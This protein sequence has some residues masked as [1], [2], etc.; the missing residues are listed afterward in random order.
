MRGLIKKAIFLRFTYAHTPNGG[1][2]VVERTWKLVELVEVEWNGSLMNVEGD[3]PVSE[4]RNE[5]TACSLP[6]CLGSLGLGAAQL[7]TCGPVSGSR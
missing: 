5:I 1:G 7:A 3:T 6:N 2:L 4:L